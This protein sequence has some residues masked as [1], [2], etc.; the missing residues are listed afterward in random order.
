MAPIIFDGHTLVPARQVFEP[1]GARVDWDPDNYVVSIE[2]NGNLV[3]L[4]QDRMYGYVGNDLFRLPIAPKIISADGQ[5]GQLM[6]PARFVS[7][8]IDLSVEWNDDTSTVSISEKPQI[9]NQNLNQNLSQSQGPNTNLTSA[10][11]NTGLARDVSPSVITE[12]HHPQTRILNIDLPTTQNGYSFGIQAASAISRVETMLLNDNR[13]VI[14]IFN[15]EMALYRTSHDTP[16]TPADRIRAAQHEL[17]GL[18]TRVV[19]ELNSP[20]DYIVSISNDRR[21]VTISFVH[22][23][24]TNVSFSTDGNN[25]FIYI[26]FDGSPSSSL[27]ALA[28][29]SRILIDVPT[30]MPSSLNIFEGA[31]NGRFVESKRLEQTGGSSNRIILNLREDARYETQIIGNRLIITISEPTYRNIFVDIE[32]SVIRIAKTGNASIN[33]NSVGRQDLFHIGQYVFTLPGDFSSLLGFGRMPINTQ[34][35]DSV[36]IQNNAAGQTE[37]IVNQ[38]QILAYEITESANFIYITPMSPRQRYRHVVLLDPGHGGND[39]GAIANGL[40]EAELVLDIVLRTMQ[41]FER[42]N[43]GI[44]AYSTRIDNTRVDN[45]RRATMGNQAA[46]LF[47]SVHFNSVDL[48]RNPGS[49]N[50]NGT[51]TYYLPRDGTPNRQV[52]EVFHRNLLSFLGTADR[53][54]RNEEWT[55]LVN[56]TIPAVLLEIGFLTNPTEAANIAAPGFN[57]RAAEAIYASIVEVFNT[58][59]LRN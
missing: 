53:R 45:V 43:S 40:V 35:I 32:R 42:S 28:N 12:E 34:F 31:L 13:L 16:N 44:K 22:S 11:N 38:N 52:A 54:I 33:V 50:A 21:Q 37:I 26:D 55:V 18:K 56:S 4:G 59:Q 8:A 6:I 15:A 27:L 1:L 41:L 10:P 24:I 17:P 51:E 39:P 48:V 14:D 2:Y 7:E 19:L 30:T 3:A 46:D 29:P 58:Y 36:Y 23:N 49:I 20:V 25:D 57:Q 47:V 5:N 9:P